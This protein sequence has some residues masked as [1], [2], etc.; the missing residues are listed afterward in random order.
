MEGGGGRGERGGE[1]RVGRGG[2]GRGREG[3]G[4]EGINVSARTHRGVHADAS[5]F[6]LGNFITDA[7]V[8]QV[9]DDPAAI[10]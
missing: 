6:P 1:G 7:I 5:V 3:K 2:E 9:T 8:R 10:I 4:G